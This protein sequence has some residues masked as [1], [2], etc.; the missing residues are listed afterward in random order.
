MK[1]YKLYHRT[2]KK[3]VNLEKKQ[4]ENIPCDDWCLEINGLI[5]YFKTE[6]DAKKALAYEMEQDFSI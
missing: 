5:G 1:K 2:E 4:W 3:Q 6:S